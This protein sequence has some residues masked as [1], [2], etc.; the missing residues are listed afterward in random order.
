MSWIDAEMGEGFRD[1]YRDVRQELPVQNNYS[2]AYIHGWRNG[3]DDRTSNPRDTA[4][5]LRKTA[6]FIRLSEPWTA[7]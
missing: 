4:E 2:A 7:N 1:G 3:R 6:Q 5:N